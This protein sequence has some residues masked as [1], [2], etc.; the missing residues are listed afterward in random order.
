[1]IGQVVEEKS[2]VKAAIEAD[3]M[4]SKIIFEKFLWSFGW[5]NDIG[6]ILSILVLTKLCT[7]CESLFLF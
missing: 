1:M 4:R 5:K 6:K 7:L 2:N 3:L